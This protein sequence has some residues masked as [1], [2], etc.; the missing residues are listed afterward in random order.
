VSDNLDSDTVASFGYE[1]ERHS[2]SGL[3]EKELTDI[4]NSYFKIFPWHQLDRNAEGFD[5][6]C[7]SGR[8]ATLAAPRVGTLNCIDPSARALE[9]A[10]ANLNTAD[11]V[12]F[13]N[14]A[15]DTVG[16]KPASQ[17]FGYSLGVLHHVPDTAAAIASC[18]SLLKPGAPLLLYLYYRFD[19]RPAWFRMLWAVSDVIRSGLSRLPHAVKSFATDVIALTV[20]WP[21]S[22]FAWALEKIG[23]EVEDFPLSAYRKLSFYTMRTDSLDRFGTPLE[24]RFTRSEITAM[25]SAAGLRNIQFHDGVPYWCAVGYRAELNSSQ[26]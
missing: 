5:M 13:H 4:F 19:N 18:A 8:W 17:D 11:N 14:A 10:K 1:W 7:G 16:L 22:R 25:M 15:V 21:L 3:S 24:Q 23:L 12:R 9:V 6:G 20:Y 2:Q 26:D